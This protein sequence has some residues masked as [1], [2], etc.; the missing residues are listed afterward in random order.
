META[1]SSWTDN[2]WIINYVLDFV[3]GLIT[4]SDSTSIIGFDI[5]VILRRDFITYNAGL[6]LG[7]YT[8]PSTRQAVELFLAQGL[9]RSVFD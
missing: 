1:D 9:G 6:V 2:G 4:S 7:R 3:P 5:P 8:R